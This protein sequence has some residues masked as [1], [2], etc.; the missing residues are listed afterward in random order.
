MKIITKRI[1]F[2]EI[3]QE[4]TMTTSK[5]LTFNTN[6]SP[7]N[8]R[9]PTNTELTKK[10]PTIVTD[11]LNSPEYPMNYEQNKLFL[12]QYQFPPVPF[13]AEMKI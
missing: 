10:T 1:G 13:Y 4:I 8:K 2:A 5:Y 9:T 6:T 11:T 3:D 7:S 12:S